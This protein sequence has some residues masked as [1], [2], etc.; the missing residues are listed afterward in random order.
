MTEDTK[1]AMEIIKPLADELNITVKADNR[2]LYI[3]EMGIG[4]VQNSTWATIW[5]FVGYLMVRYDRKFRDIRLRQDQLDSIMRY[6]L[7]SDQ[8]RKIQI[9]DEEVD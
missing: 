4:I 8:L 7:T 1:K 3:D 9:E 5:E 2:I 6:W